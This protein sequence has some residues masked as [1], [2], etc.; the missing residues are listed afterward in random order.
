MEKN[1][2]YNGWANYETW[3]LALNID[4]DEGLYNWALK[5]AELL[6]EDFNG[7]YLKGYLEEIAEFKD[8]GYK[9][10]DFWSCNEWREIDFEE[11]AEAKRN[12][13]KENA[14]YRKRKETKRV[15]GR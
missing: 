13:V 2:K 1:N 15:L 4:N 12:E 3:K 5:M 6:G 10:C 14:E 9:L 7:E 8:V 11:V